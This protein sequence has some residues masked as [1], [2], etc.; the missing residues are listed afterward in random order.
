MLVVALAF[1]LIFPLEF[2]YHSLL[3]C[4]LFDSFTIFPPVFCNKVKNPPSGV[5]GATTL[6]GGGAGG[7]SGIGMVNS[8]G[9]T[10]TRLLE[11]V[12]SPHKGDFLFLPEQVCLWG[13]PKKFS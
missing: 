5:G 6:G 2:M 4:L 13:N 3:W 8:V 10:R 1:T 7:G 9:R 12:P 11:A